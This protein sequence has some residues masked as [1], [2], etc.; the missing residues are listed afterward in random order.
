MGQRETEADFYSLFLL[1]ETCVAVSELPE[2]FRDK[3]LA[4]HGQDVML[5]MKKTLTATD[6]N[7]GQS[8]LSIPKSQILA[9]FL[10]RDEIRTLDD[11]K[12]IL[13]SLIEPCLEVRHDLQL[14]K[15]K[16][17]SG[18]FSYVLT[19]HWN[20]VAHPFERNRLKKDSLIQ[21]WSFR[22]NGN[23]HFCLVNLGAP[24]M[25]THE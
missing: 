4:M 15:W 18:T 24:N 23:L 6:M 5:V 12:G 2:I 8:R 13:V 25:A 16:N 10:S 9:D 7:P 21:L 1:A 14:K 17:K 20:A 19:K 11:K 3:I 22:V